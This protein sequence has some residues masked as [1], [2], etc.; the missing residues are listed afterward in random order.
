MAKEKVM[1]EEM[2]TVEEV[3]VEEALQMEIIFSQALT[4]VLIAKGLITEEEVL[5]RVE[6]I[7][8]ETG[9]ELPG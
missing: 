9:F 6:E 3:L 5:D 4:D 2:E 7:K 8:T 1:S